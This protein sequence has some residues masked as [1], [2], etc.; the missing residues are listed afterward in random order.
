MKIPALAGPVLRVGAV[1]L[2]AAAC[3]QVGRW[4][5]QLETRAAAVDPGNQMVVATF[6][7][8]PEPAPVKPLVSAG[9]PVG[10]SGDVITPLNV[11][12]PSALVMGPS[13]SS[14]PPSAAPAP[15]APSSVPKDKLRKKPLA[16]GRLLEL[17]RKQDRKKDLDLPK[18]F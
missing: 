14:Y 17:L 2:L 4:T 1:L 6:H 7:G 18:A 5:G 9:D 3:F 15:A 16:D 8:A 10:Q 11:R 12:D 13:G